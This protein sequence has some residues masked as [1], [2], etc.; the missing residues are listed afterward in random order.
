M[1]RS[2]FVGYRRSR[3]QMLENVLYS[4]VVVSY[5]KRV[6]IADTLNQILGLGSLGTSS[7]FVLYVS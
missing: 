4:F 5:N 1:P 3:A 7:K 2:L 6:Y